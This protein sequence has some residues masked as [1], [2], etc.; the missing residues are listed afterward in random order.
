VLAFLLG[1]ATQQY[2]RH[3]SR[4]ASPAKT[5]DAAASTASPAPTTKVM[6][7]VENRSSNAND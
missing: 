2:R 6:R 5:L 7:R 1:L 3:H 4:P